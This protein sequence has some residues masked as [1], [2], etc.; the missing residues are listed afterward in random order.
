ML[1]MCV[2]AMMVVAAAAGCSTGSKSDASTPSAATVSS[3]E[4]VGGSSVDDTTAGLEAA[5]AAYTK[6]FGTGD[7]DAAWATVSQRCKKTVPEGQFRAAVLGG[8]ALRPDMV[9]TDIVAE[10][11]GTQGR[12]TYKTT[13]EGVGPYSEQ[14]WRYEDGAWHWD[15][16]PSY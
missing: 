11:D 16:C 3:A 15:D 12:A 6:A 5:V 13:G 7:A 9:A 14:P 8:P 2:I 4:S 10:V 1:R